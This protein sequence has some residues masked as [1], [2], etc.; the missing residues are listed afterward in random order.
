MVNIGAI[1]VVIF[2]SLLKGI[3][4]FGFALLSLPLLMIWYS[5]KELI[6]VLVMCNLLA[7]VFI[8]LQKKEKKLI[9]KKFMSLIIFGGIFT[10]SGVGVLKYID[11]GF[12]IQIVSGLFIILCLLSIFKVRSNINLPKWTYSLAGSIIG[13]LT[14]SISVSG[15]PLA[16]FLNQ[17][18]TSNQTFRE[19]FAWFSIV[20]S[21][22][23][24]VGYFIAGLISR[25]SIEMVLVFAPILLIG[26]VLG[27]RLNAVIPAQLFKNISVVITLISCV[28]LLI[29]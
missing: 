7:S 28:I 20:T 17:T 9:D 16:L 22:V 27:K 18:N 10:I 4:G 14:G 1:V 15:P 8:I 21:V 26:A 2:S 29:S 11:E 6:P 5:P 3:T 25:Q 13:F 23:A 24:V 12:L 19:V